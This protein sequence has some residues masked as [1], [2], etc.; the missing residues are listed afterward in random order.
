MPDVLKNFITEIIWQS[1]K[2]LEAIP[3][4]S[5]LSNSLEIDSL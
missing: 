3:V 5:N 2:A 4:F 1:I